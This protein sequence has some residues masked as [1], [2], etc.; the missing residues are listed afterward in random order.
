MFSATPKILKC[1]IGRRFPTE[2]GLSARFPSIKEC[3]PIAAC[4]LDVQAHL[5]GLHLANDVVQS[6]GEL[7][8][9]RAG[10]HDGGEKTTTCPKHR[11]TLGLYWRASRNCAHPLHGSSKRKP[12]RSV[13]KQV[14]FEI[15]RIWKLLVQIGSGKNI[16]I[17]EFH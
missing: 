2:C 9:L 14:S 7:I 17:E 12:E 4:K 6:E 5:K 15:H 8:L 13:N 11:Q 3:L 10:I 1:S 16:E